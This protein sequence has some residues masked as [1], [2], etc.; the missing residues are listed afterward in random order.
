MIRPHLP[1]P[2]LLSFIT[3]LSLSVP[4]LAD[5]GEMFRK[6]KAYEDVSHL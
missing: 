6:R 2:L 5:I 3:F 1:L 4:R